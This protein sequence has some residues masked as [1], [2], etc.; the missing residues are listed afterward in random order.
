VS[1]IRALRAALIAVI[2]FSIVACSHPPEVRSKVDIGI[3]Y[4]GGPPP[5]IPNGSQP[6]NIEV[7]RPDGSVVRSVYLEGG[8]Q[9]FAELEAG[10]YRVEASSGDAVCLAQN[11]TV[12]PPTRRTVRI[13]CSVK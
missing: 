12:T 9:Y 10:R 7:L 3:V 2:P 8:D 1:G 6:G 5:G 11:I 13:I 4:R